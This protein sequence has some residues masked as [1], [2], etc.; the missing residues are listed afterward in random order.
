MATDPGNATGPL[1]IEAVAI[2]GAN[3]RAYLSAV[4]QAYRKGRVALVVPPRAEIKS[5]P[6]VKITEWQSFADEPGWFTEQL[7]HIDSDAQAQI[8]FSSGTTGRPKPLLLTHN[9]LS[10]VVK[11]INAAMEI[12][13]S[14]KE[15]LG[16][17]AAFSFGFG[18][19]RAVAAAGGRTYLPPHGFDP[20]EIARM[21]K[22]GEINAISAVPT[23]WRMILANPQVIGDAGRALRWIEIGSQYRAGAEKAGIKKLFPQAKIVQHYGLTEASRTTLLDVS[24]TVGDA[25]ESVGRA[26]GAVEVVIGID[27]AI[28]IRGPHLARGLVTGAGVKPITDAEGWLTTS[29]L[30]RIEDGMLYYRGRSDELI[31][32]GGIKID[33]VQFE[34][35][36]GQA[37][38][39]PS[40][41]AVGRIE[42][43][44]RG[45][46]V[47]VVY[48]RN[49]GIE[50]EAIERAA[51]LVAAGFG[52]VGSGSLTFRQT[53]EFP[54]TATGKIQRN[55]LAVLED[56]PAPRTQPVSSLPVTESTDNRANDLQKI[57]AEVLGVSSVS[58]TESF[59]DLG[60]DSL[61]A[62][63]VIIRME[64]LGLDSQTARGIFD[65]KSIADITGITG[66]DIL[67]PTEAPVLPRRPVQNNS[68]VS[69][70]AKELQRVWAEVL[71]LPS[72]SLTESF[73]DLGG[74]SL[75][76]LTAIMRMEAVG[77]DPNT[78]RGIFDGKTIADLVG[79]DD[80]P[81]SITVADT[82]PPTSAPVSGATPLRATLTLAESMNAVHA[83]RGVLIL[84]VVV[85]HWLPGVLVRIS[86][87]ALWI[88]EALD[89]ALRFGTPGFAM[90]FGLGIGA[91]GIP[92]YRK[93]RKIFLKRARF[94]CGLIV[95][96]VLLLA[97]FKWG[98]LLSEGR[99]DDPNLLSIM[100][101]SAISYYALAML[102]LPLIMRVLDI[103]SNTFLTILTAA[104]GFLLV[105]EILVETVAPLR[106]DG[107]LEL[108]KILLTA[109]YGYFHMTVYVM[110]GA[111]IGYMFRAHHTTQAMLQDLV[112]A[113]FALIV[114]GGLLTYM[115]Q[116]DAMLVG[117]N[118][119]LPWHL[120][121]YAGLT[122]LILSGFC[123]L[124]RGG[125]TGSV[126]PLRMFNAAAI[127]CGILALPIFV[128]SGIVIPA[129]ALLVNLGIPNILA[130]MIP[131]GLFLVML[132]LAFGK[133]MR[134]IAR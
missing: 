28:K 100:F 108:I 63:T 92:Q 110:V 102:T 97:V 75:S 122:L 87:S 8:S 82:L 49:S 69:G 101:Y 25:L 14:I 58:L 89:P 109:K 37:L 125:G 88:Y 50:R 70:R 83:T 114:F 53:D 20:S 39:A 46:K 13:S 121:V 99:L 64:S 55:A 105:H 47:L 15:Y 7:D 94:N 48:R 113:G 34:H 22:A 77:L 18:R 131:L 19:V 93:N 12:D 3:S 79:L 1:L 111:A 45:E 57:W 56:R 134:F 23:L 71:N 74:D 84:W 67:L 103:G 86:D 119:V 112:V 38:D 29:D 68:A 123:A 9:A 51:T 81:T 90:V 129:K 127:V 2:A 120:M 116:P 54:K 107:I 21:L 126:R 6:G 128:G 91:L 42:D 11:R 10:D 62:L 130:L 85:V 60:G 24:S 40:E 5:V 41:V 65:G 80:A 30:G 72:V 124:N 78:V 117:F 26:T 61:S 95:L 76:A 52:L 96:G 4:F 32:S 98:V 73:Y 36:L 16:V 33:P 104:V 115:V 27:G 44:L 59:Y 118:E 66:I 133:L 35:K 31:N 106:P 43:S 132:G 17:P